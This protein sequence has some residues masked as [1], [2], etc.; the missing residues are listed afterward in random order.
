MI[1]LNGC[2]LQ[3]NDSRDDFD[4]ARHRA[5]HV[6]ILH[7]ER[8]APIYIHEHCGLCIQLRDTG[9]NANRGCAEHSS[10]HLCQAVRAIADAGLGHRCQR[11]DRSRRRLDRDRL[12]LG[13]EDDDG[14]SVATLG[15]HKLEDRKQGQRQ[16]CQQPPLG[17]PAPAS[18]GRWGV[19][20]GVAGRV[21]GHFRR[22]EPFLPGPPIRR[23]CRAY[24]S[25]CSGP[26]AGGWAGGQTGPASGAD[27]FLAAGHRH[28]CVLTVGVPARC[29]QLHSAIAVH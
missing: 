15:Q 1:V 23:R 17:A 25:R 16:R 28:S 10:G 26:A 5:G 24:R 9:G 20:G 4:G 14:I 12:R 19:R 13:L 3:G 29:R 11:R 8:L 22:R 6:V 27:R 21:Y 2:M 18:V 7:V